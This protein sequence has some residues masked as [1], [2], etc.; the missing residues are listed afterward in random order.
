M[1]SIIRPLRRRTAPRKILDTGDLLNRLVEAIAGATLV[2][3]VGIFARLRDSAVFRRRALE[4]LVGTTCE[5]VDHVLAVLLEQQQHLLP[6]AL[7]EAWAVVGA[8]VE[9]AI[10]M[11][12]SA[13]R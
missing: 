9:V 1:T 2:S 12:P 8:V 7:H 10:G 3:R 13:S 11:G 6:V 4:R 5:G